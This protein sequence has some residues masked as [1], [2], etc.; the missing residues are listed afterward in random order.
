[1]LQ[2]K[3]GVLNFVTLA[4]ISAMKEIHIY[5]YFQGYEKSKGLAIIQDFA[6]H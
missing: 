5:F 4:Y 2:K 6:A 1:V 3:P